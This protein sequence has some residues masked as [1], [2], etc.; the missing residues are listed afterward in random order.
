MSRDIIAI[1]S[2]VAMGLLL[3]RRYPF[4]DGDFLV[5]LTRAESPWLYLGLRWSWLTMLYTTP[6]L[7]FAGIFSLVYIFGGSGKRK[8]GGD[9]PPFPAPTDDKPL[10]LVIGEVHH[11]RRVEPVDYPGWLKIPERGLFT[12]IAVFGSTG[13]GK[14]T[15]AMRPFAEQIF[16]WRAGYTDRR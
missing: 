15:A 8:A 2:A 6:A 10:H 4:P 5:Q 16:S 14:T 12:G 7:F 3:T 13:S 1:L 11:P 9:L